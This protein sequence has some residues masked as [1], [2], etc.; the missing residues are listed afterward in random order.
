MIE[1]DRPVVECRAVEPD[2]W[3]SRCG[4][5]GIPRGSVVRRLAHV[6]FGMRPNTLLVRVRRYLCSGCG[7]LWRQD[8]TMAAEPP[9]RSCRVVRCEG[10]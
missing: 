2:G 4:A 7:R 3:C 9:D 1:P 6:P 5:E 8:L 10:R